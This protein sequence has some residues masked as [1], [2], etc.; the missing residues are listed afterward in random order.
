[1][2][3]VAEEEKERALQRKKIR[4]VFSIT[5]LMYFGKFNPKLLEHI[6]RIF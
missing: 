4:K 2:T 5:Y 3:T 6:L 1:M